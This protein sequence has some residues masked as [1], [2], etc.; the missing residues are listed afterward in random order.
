MWFRA[1][2]TDHFFGNR[3]RFQ[4]RTQTQQLGHGGISPLDMLKVEGPGG[5]DRF[6]MVA[7]QLTTAAQQLHAM[8]AVEL[9]VHHEIATKFFDIVQTQKSLV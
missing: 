8:G 6:G 5:G 1:S 4:K 7:R 3:V 2:L 9:K